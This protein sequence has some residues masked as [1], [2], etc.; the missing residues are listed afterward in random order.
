MTAAHRTPISKE[1]NRERGVKEDAEVK[2]T[3]WLLFQ[4]S[5]VLT[6]IHMADHNHL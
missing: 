4:R 2:I 6:S 3:H 5:Q 1:V